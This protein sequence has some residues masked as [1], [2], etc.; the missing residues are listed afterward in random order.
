MAEGTEPRSG[1]ALFGGSGTGSAGPGLIFHAGLTAYDER[2]NP[3]PRLAQKIPSLADGDWKVLPD[4]TME[5]TWKLRPN[6]KWH[7]GAPLT[8]DDLLFG[9]RLVQDDQVPL[10]RG[11][12]SRLV[13]DVRALDAETL[14]MTWRQT[15]LLANASGA[16]DLA[17][18]PVHQMGEL[19]QAG[20]RAAFLNNPYWS[21][22]FV[23]LG[24][25]RVGEWTLGSSLEAIAFDDYFL[26]RPKI[27]RI[28]IRYI[29]DANTLLAALLSGDVDVVPV[30][31]MAIESVAAAKKTWESNGAGTVT[32]IKSGLG[33]SYL[34]YRDTTAPWAADVRVRR[35]LVHLLDREA[36]VD[37]LENGTTAVAD[38]VP[39]PDDPVYNL[40]VQR[41]LARYP[42]DVARADRLL[43]DA[44]WARGADGMY[45]S[46]AGQRLG[47]EVRTLAKNPEDVRKMVTQAEMWRAAGIE[48]STFAIPN[49]VSAIQRSEMRSNVPGIFASVSEQNQPEGLN[50]FHSS[51]ISSE[52]TRWSGINP[53]GYS[54][55]AFDRL[56]D[57]YLGTLDISTRQGLLADL[58][59]MAADQVIFLPVDYWVGTVSIAVRKGVTGPGPVNPIQL[60]STWNVHTWDMQ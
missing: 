35:A 19:Y 57:Q 33:I 32:P 6:V 31:T 37:A 38:T 34:Q 15:Y 39:T 55:P 12:W 14:Q 22:A 18:V 42:Y 7:D 36:F 53:G 51:Q 3:T 44:G 52:R 20:D 50:A 16:L 21:T 2:G 60:A 47:F 49:E 30:G 46:A 58:L 11:S 59:V 43:N 28:V 5:I 13:T 25:Y 10:S 17:A 29:G 23:G 45:Q 40:V 1:L 41:G 27:D 48:T 9:W 8:I 56:Y 54:N 24:P 4:G 26:G